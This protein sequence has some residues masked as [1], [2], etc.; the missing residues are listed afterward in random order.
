VLEEHLPPSHYH[1]GGQRV[2]K[3]QRLL[4][5]AN[6]IFLGWNES[7]VSG[8][9]YYWRQLRD[10]KGSVDVDRSAPETLAR[11]ARL[12]GII[13]AR[14]HAVSGDPAAISEYLGKGDVFDEALGEFS[15]AYA[16]Q[17][18]ADHVTFATAIRDGHLEAAELT[19]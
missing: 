5:A 13:L 11:Y 15:F 12:C 17:N 4:Q 16:K 10:W 8:H 2:V 9:Q 19:E 7:A 18:L 3:G 1:Q 14:T 6:Y